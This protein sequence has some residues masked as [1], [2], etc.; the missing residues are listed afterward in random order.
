MDVRQL[1]AT[2]ILSQEEQEDFEGEEGWKEESVSAFR[3]RVVYDLT[4]RFS[5]CLCIFFLF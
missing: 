3:I 2:L 1:I 4:F 5:F